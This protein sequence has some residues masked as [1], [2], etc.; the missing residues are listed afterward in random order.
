MGGRMTSLAAAKEPLDGVRGIVFV[1]F[2]LH[3]AGKPSADRGEHL[4]SVR[5]PM[6][7]LQGTRDTLADLALLRPVCDAL[8]SRATLRIFDDADHSFHVRKKSGRDDAAV[9]TELA[10]TSAA[11]MRDVAGDRA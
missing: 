11:W 2:P 6:L 9:L 3:A 7:F 1:G 10:E 4:A 5:V 8:G